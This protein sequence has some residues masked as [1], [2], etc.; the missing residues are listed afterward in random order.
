MKAYSPIGPA[1]GGCK[2]KVEITNEGT[3]SEIWFNVNT[4]AKHGSLL[5]VFILISFTVHCSLHVD[6]R[7]LDFCFH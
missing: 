5:C 4:S 2:S 6:R 7:H 3:P 1:Q